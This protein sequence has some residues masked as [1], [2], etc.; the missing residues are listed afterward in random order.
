MNNLCLKLNCVA[1]RAFSSL[2][3]PWPGW[4]L[5]QFAPGF[6]QHFSSCCHNQ[7]QAVIRVFSTFGVHSHLKC[8]SG[9][10]SSQK[11]SQ[12]ILASHS[13]HLQPPPSLCSPFFLPCPSS[14]EV[15]SS[16]EVTGTPF[17]L[18]SVFHSALLVLSSPPRPALSE[19][20]PSGRVA[21]LLTSHG[22]PTSGQ[23][24]TFT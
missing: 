10:S 22:L 8:F 18:L 13:L 16:G 14:G 12:L 7:M 21:P 11:S 19:E 1:W 2:W 4:P 6:S 17:F 20:T 24:A 9:Q 5:S 15:R 23:W 3:W